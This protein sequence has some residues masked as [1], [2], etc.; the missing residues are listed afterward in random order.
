MKKMNFLKA[1]PK[2][3]V[4]DN[5]VDAFVPEI[6]ANESLA[7][8]EENMVAASLIHRD[9]ED[10][11]AKFG[12]IVNTRRPGEYVAKRKTASDDVTVQDSTA[13][14]V[15][16]PLNQ[17]IH[18]SFLIKDGEESKSMKDLVETYM[19]PAMLAQTRII[20]RIVLGQY[21]RFL[22][23]SFGGLNTLTTNNARDRILGLRNVLN[24]NKA[25]MD[26]RRLILTP[27]TETALLGLDLFTSAEKVGD[28]G[29]ALEEAS[30]GRKYGFGMYMSQ[31]MAGVVS[32]PT[33]L[34]VTIGA[35]NNAGGYAKGTTTMTVDGLS[36]AVTAGQWFTVA[37]DDTP[38]QIVSS[39]GGATPTSLTF[40]PGLRSAVANDAVITIYNKNTTG[41]TAYANGWSK[42]ILYNGSGATVP[43]IG[44]MVSFVVEAGVTAHVYSIV[45][46]D[47]VAGTMLLDR[48]LESAVPAGS[49]INWGPAGQ[50][51]LGFHRNAMSLVVRP[52]AMPRA[53]TGALS[54]VVNLNGLS[55]RATITYNGL[56]Q[57]H[58]VT[59]D[60]LCGIAILDQNLGSVLLA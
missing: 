50:F 15:Q 41:A 35:V 9:F 45:E 27:S 36:A 59:L 21:P 53:G 19:K 55:M 44:Q 10:E 30:L 29:T 20:D 25:Y 14:N 37:G 43:Q 51:N 42:D 39:V 52:L 34:P 57:G 24:V 7:I 49:N 1:V 22:I 31:N 4:Y 2:I 58:L 17:H 28:D 60:M 11:L 38:Q 12:D 5:D 47:T 40:Y 26:G 13:V 18:V 32:N 56:K 6:W 54:S 33:T 48:P 46:V 3:N 8:L 23:N 16:V